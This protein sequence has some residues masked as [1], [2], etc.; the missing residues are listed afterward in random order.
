MTNVKMQQDLP[1][2]EDITP[3]DFWGVPKELKD[4]KGV[5]VVIANTLKGLRLLN[6]LKELDRI[7]LVEVDMKTATQKD[8]ESVINR[9][10][11][12]SFEELINKYFKLPNL[13]TFRVRRLMGSIIRR[14]LLR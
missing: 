12:M 8:Q 2:Y 13:V 11:G 6:A 4:K 9:P 5:S 7:E 10:K 1:R 14:I 3:D